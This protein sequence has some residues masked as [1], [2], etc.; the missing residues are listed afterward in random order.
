MRTSTFIVTALSTL[1]L[2]AAS[3]TT[4][5]AGFPLKAIAVLSGDSPVKGYVTIVQD[6]PEGGSKISYEVSGLEPHSNRGFHIHTYG[7]I[8]KGCT[9]PQGHF[10]PYGK[11]HGAPGDMNRHVG[12]LGNIKSNREGFAKG[13]IEDRMVRLAGPTSVLGRAF[14]VH[15]GTD[16]EGKGASADSKK[17]GNAGGRPA[18]GVIGVAP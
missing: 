4:P 1:G 9:S 17:T 7:D 12:D 3:P 18:C 13:M 15:A 5:E 10:N 6:S 11:D 16:D 8:T 2:V 14:V